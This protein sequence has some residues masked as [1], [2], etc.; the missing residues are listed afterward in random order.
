[1]I[2]IKNEKNTNK[3]TTPT[4]FTNKDSSFLFVSK[5]GNLNKKDYHKRY[6]SKPKQRL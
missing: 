5:V 2:S 6:T 1:M 4:E 3:Y